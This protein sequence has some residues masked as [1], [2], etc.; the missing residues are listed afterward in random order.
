MSVVHNCREPH[1]SLFKVPLSRFENDKWHYRMQNSTLP[2][3]P[4]QLSIPLQWQPIVFAIFVI[5]FPHFY[6]FYRIWLNLFS[7]WIPRYS[8]NMC[9]WTSN[10]QETK[11]NKHRYDTD[12]QYLCKLWCH[13]RT[14]NHVIRQW[15][16]VNK[17]DMSPAALLPSVCWINDNK[18][19]RSL[20]RKTVV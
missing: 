16:E 8:L 17:I 20:T 10:H 1:T 18:Y 4:T 5:F 14:G 9:S 6:F 2:P 3:P 19:E 12:D 13:V 7:Y 15:W 11:T